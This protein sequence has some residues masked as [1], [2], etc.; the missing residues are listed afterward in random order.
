M[1]KIIHATRRIALVCLLQS[2]TVPTY[3]ADPL[4]SFLT[5]I[6]A[7]TTLA[8]IIGAI[9]G[10]GWIICPVLVLFSGRSH[11]GAKFGWFLVALLLAW[12]GFAIF[13]I[14]TQ[15]PPERDAVEETKR[16]EHYF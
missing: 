3:A 11:G 10:G 12:L 16:I 8:F 9:I 6:P 14:V 15:K 4:H 7:P 1:H 5:H 13:L 2:L